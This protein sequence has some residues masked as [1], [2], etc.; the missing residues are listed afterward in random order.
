[1]F[2]YN[3]NTR[4]NMSTLKQSNLEK[5]LKKTTKCKKGYSE[6]EDENMLTYLYAGGELIFCT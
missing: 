3:G 6:V 4:V 1:M 2:F 5:Y